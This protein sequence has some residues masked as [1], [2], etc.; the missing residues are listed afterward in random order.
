MNPEQFAQFL[1]SNEKSTRDAIEHHVNGKIDNLSKQLTE[2]AASDLKY[3]EKIDGNI[4]W[5]VKLIIGAVILGV[6]AMLF[7]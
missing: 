2:H 5:V 4:A 7:K 3:Q 1:V 6:I